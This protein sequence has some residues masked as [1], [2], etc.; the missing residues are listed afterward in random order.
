VGP[1]RKHVRVLSNMEMAWVAGGYDSI[2]CELPAGDD[3]GDD[4]YWDF[5]DPTDSGD[6]GGDPP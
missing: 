3:G 6:F 1:W 2:V 4:G 5:P